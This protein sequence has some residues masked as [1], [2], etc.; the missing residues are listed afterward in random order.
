[1]D[2]A[3]I[4]RAT[5]EGVAPAK[6]VEIDG[7]LVP[8][9]AG[10]IGRA[11]S[12]V[13]LSHTAGADA[14]SG[15]EAAYWTEGLTPAFRIAEARG[16]A[17]VQAALATRGYA[18]AKPTVVKV[19]DV[20][21]LATLRDTPGEILERPDA[22]WGAVFLGEG[23][24]PEE[25]ASRVAALSRSPDAVYAQVREDGRTVAVGV[26][27]FG[28]GWAGVHGMRTAQARRG[29]GLASQV[30][31]AL[32]QAIAARGVDQVFLQ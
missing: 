26:A 4:E 11:K 29:R 8:L 12:A 32:G 17:P 25:G 6:L 15:I 23:F 1:M 30:L 5:V 7:W 19:G 28:H 24:D 18:G 14:L 3:A 13:P 9:D 16:L 2:I 31:A 10:P 27:T 22:A 20:G 21:R